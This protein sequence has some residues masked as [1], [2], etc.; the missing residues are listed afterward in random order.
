MIGYPDQGFGV[1]AVDLAFR[2]RN[3]LGDYVIDCVQSG[4]RHPVVI[5][6]LNR[7]RSV[8]Q[9]AAILAAKKRSQNEDIDIIA[10]NLADSTFDILFVNVAPYIDQ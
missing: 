1:Q 7:R 4:R 9:N 2:V 8:G 6:H 5:A 3:V 10:P